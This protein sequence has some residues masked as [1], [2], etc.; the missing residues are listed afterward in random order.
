MAIADRCIHP[1]KSLAELL[2]RAVALSGKT[3]GELAER[4][5]TRIDAPA[6]RTK[7]RIGELLECALGASA[8]CQDGPD[9][10]ALGV[11][12][13]TIPVD[14]RGRVRESTFI[15][16]IDFQQVDREEWADSRA[17][18]KLQQVL[19]VPVEAREVA[20]MLERKVG[21]PL[22]WRPSADEQAQLRADWELLI[23]ELA[24]GAGDELSAHSGQ[25]LQVR[26]KAANSEVLA[27]RWSPEGEL[28]ATVPRGFYLRARFTQQLLW[29]LSESA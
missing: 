10:P 3:V 8:G 17:W 7:G 15:C 21:E 22:L 1:P 9:F 28:V 29:R 23:G 11:E 4:F 20:P 14:R 6:T 26:P 27:E 25:L 12:L 13:K 16:S 5:D 24:M 2:A 19:W 18:R